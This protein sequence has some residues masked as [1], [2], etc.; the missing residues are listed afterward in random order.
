MAFC[1]AGTFPPIT[2][3]TQA[4]MNFDVKR[5]VINSAGTRDSSG[6][7]SDSALSAI[8]SNLATSGRLVS[9]EVYNS[10]FDKDITKGTRENSQ[11][12][13]NTLGKK[14]DLLMEDIK[15]EFCFNYIRYKYSLTRL[16]DAI[17]STSTGTTLTDTQK[18]DIQSKLDRAK[19]FNQN[20]ND[21]VQI[22]N[23]IAKK[24]SEEM[25]T[26]NQNI[27]ALNSSITTTFNKLQSNNALLKREDAV[28]ELRKRMT[29]FSQ[30]KNLSANNLLALYGFLNLVSIGLLFY[31]YRK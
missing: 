9:L 18:N 21:L 2:N 24:R 12:M 17:V 16:F 4:N 19:K 3:D 15:H 7:L 6:L 31:I 23:Y 13:L 10:N 14:E 28:A 20:L 5:S 25:G 11:V 8:Y 30:E 22:N 26:Q 27:N 29:E 1:D